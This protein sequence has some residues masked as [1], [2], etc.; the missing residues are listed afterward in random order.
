MHSLKDSNPEVYKI[1]SEENLV[2]RRAMVENG[3]DTRF[4]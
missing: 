2:I 4:I 3:Q 1:F